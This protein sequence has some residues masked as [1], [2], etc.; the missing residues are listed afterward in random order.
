MTKVETKRNIKMRGVEN[1]KNVKRE[2]GQAKQKMPK[3]RRVRPIGPMGRWG[4]WVVGANWSCGPIAPHL[5]MGLMGRS[6]LKFYI[7]VVC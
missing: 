3:V 1:D 7:D 2:T 4:L 5:P 6:P